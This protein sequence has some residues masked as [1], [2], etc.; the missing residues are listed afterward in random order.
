MTAAV[1]DALLT[2]RGDRKEDEGVGPHVSPS[3]GRIWTQFRNVASRA[4]PYG[5]Y[6]NGAAMRV[7]S[8]AWLAESE[9]DCVALARASAMPTHNPEGIKGA[10]ATAWT[11]WSARWGCRRKRREELARRYSMTSRARVMKSART[12]LRSRPAREPAPKYH[13]RARGCHF[14]SSR[15]FI[16]AGIG[17]ARGQRGYRRGPLRG[18]FRPE[19]SRVSQR[20]L[21]AS[22]RALPRRVGEG[23]LPISAPLTPPIPK[24]LLALTACVETN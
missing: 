21:A 15:G 14:A 4:K 23:N 2:V 19:N 12:P 24:P 22:G 13:R 1:A 8:A 10:E 20:A 18:A 3:R 11:I 7:S 9:A 17:H 6:G 16:S 5:S